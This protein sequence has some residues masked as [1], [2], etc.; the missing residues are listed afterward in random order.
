M[1]LRQ[2]QGMKSHDGGLIAGHQRVGEP[3]LGFGCKTG[4]GRF[5]EFGGPPHSMWTMANKGQ[6]GSL[7]SVVWGGNGRGVV[8]TTTGALPGRVGRIGLGGPGCWRAR[9]KGGAEEELAGRRWGGIGKPG[10]ASSGPGLSGKDRPAPSRGRP[11]VGVV[12]SR[13]RGPRTR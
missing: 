6:G 2:E 11:G 3:G 1:A 12:R 9:G 5:R 7:V 13:C 10:P 4:P 8:L